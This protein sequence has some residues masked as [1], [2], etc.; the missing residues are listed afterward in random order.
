[1][2]SI[3]IKVDYADAIKEIRSRMMAARNAA[4]RDIAIVAKIMFQSTVQTIKEPIK[5]RQSI[6]KGGARIAVG[7]DS[8]KY[9]NIVNGFEY[10]TL[11]VGPDKRRHGFVPKTKVRVLASFE[12]IGTAYP[13]VLKS[14]IAAPGRAFPDEIV[15]VLTS[16]GAGSQSAKYIAESN[17]KSA[18][19]GRKS[20]I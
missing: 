1:M 11:L 6:S 3:R 2:A 17:Y 12:Q 16:A 4:A 20:G 15:T 14:P 10:K 7:T 19:S 18:L 5:F 8:N 9:K 13:D